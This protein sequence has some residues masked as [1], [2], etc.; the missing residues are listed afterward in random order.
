MTG[1]LT[2]LARA[3]A[4]ELPR[5]FVEQL[6]EALCQGPDAVL[7]LPT[8][9]LPTSAAILREAL[10]IARTGDGPFLSGALSAVLEMADQSPAVIPVWTGPESERASGRLTLGVLA[11]LIAEARSEILLVSYATAPGAEVRSAI[12][13]AVERGVRVT[14]LLERSADNPQFTGS[15]DP[16]PGIDAVRLCWPGARRP[17]GA[18][19]HAKLLVIDRS[20]ALVGSANLTGFG[21]E[22]NFEC[23][24]LLRGGPVPA[25]I[26]EH[27][28]ATPAFVPQH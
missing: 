12:G 8:P 5:A 4:E 21:L 7:A 24:I 3:W 27:L 23:G 16:L 6:A 14:L 19:L 17:P 15:A 18:S 13:D 11:D 25:A 26:A 22:R 2:T 10:R 9:A 28:L 1:E 20:T